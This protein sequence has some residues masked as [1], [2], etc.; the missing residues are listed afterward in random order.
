ME[1]EASRRSRN[2]MPPSSS[3]EA[4]T[5]GSA[6]TCPH[7]LGTRTTSAHGSALTGRRRRVRPYQSS[8]HISHV[9]TLVV[10][11]YQLL[12]SCADWPTTE[13]AAAEGMRSAAVSRGSDGS[14]LDLSP[15][16]EGHRAGAPGHART[17]ARMHAR[18]HARTHAAVVGRCGMRWR[19]Q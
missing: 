9:S 2:Q 6:P 15:I 8:Q 1:T 12:C 5:A 10:V 19:R 13:G 3:M 4:S 7:L 18:T 17:H 16:K 11:T 14:V